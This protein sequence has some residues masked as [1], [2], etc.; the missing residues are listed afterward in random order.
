MAR[1]YVAAPGVV[2]EAIASA[3]ETPFEG[4]TLTGAA[5]TDNSGGTA[6][7]T[8][9]SQV[10]QVEVPVTLPDILLTSTDTPADLV[11]NYVV[12]IAGDIVRWGFITQVVATDG[13]SSDVDLDLQIGSTPVTGAAFA[14]LAVADF[15]AIGKV[16]QSAAL[17]AANTITTS[18]T[19]SIVCT[20]STANF[21]AG[22][23]T[24]IVWIRLPLAALANAIA[25]LAAQI[26]ANRVDIAALKAALD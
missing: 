1:N 9:A 2:A 11:T 21:T 5:L 25:S 19:I 12:G 8:I 20:E 17:T 13:G 7:A 14:A 3:V 15:N 4:V 24:P 6:S 18:S 22:V 10:L 23:I 16:K 26:E